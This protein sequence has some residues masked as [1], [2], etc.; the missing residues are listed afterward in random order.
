M[1]R[2]IPVVLL[3]GKNWSKKGDAKA[4]FREILNRYTVWD[5]VTNADDIS[6]LVAILT[7][8]DENLPPAQ[9]KIGVGIDYF[10]KRPDQEHEGNS[11]CF[12]VVRTD[13]TSVDFSIHKA[14]DATAKG[15]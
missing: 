2:S 10:E 1:G 4:H 8:Y 14:L 5:R 12:F 11:A 3:N 6:D 15:G 13:G 7:V 9:S